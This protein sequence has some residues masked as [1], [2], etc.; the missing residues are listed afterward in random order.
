LKRKIIIVLSVFFIIFMGVLFVYYLIKGDSTRW[1]VAGGGVVV[2]SLPLF[3]LFMKNNPINIPLILA[4]YLFI[5]CTIFLGSIEGFYLRFKWWDS[6]LHFF[7]G[8]LLGF[9]GIVL[10]KQFIPEKMRKDVSRWF[11]FLFVFS[12]SVTAG[13]LWEIYEFI[14]DQ[15]ITHTMQLGGNTDTMMDLLLGTAGA[16]LVAIYSYIRKPKL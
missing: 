10:F 14:G 4:F 6:P 9:L 16:L 8:I 5:F 7:K 2:S 15:T 12:L 11:I 1:M 3:L 13:D